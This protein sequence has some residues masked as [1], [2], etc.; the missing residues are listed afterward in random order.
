[1]HPGSLLAPVVHVH[2]TTLSRDRAKSSAQSDL[3]LRHKAYHKVN[4]HTTQDYLVHQ[5]ALLHL[6]AEGPPLLHLIHGSPNA[7]SIDVNNSNIT[8]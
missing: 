5:T 6:T 8:G 4:E 1:M 7:E 2:T 3:K